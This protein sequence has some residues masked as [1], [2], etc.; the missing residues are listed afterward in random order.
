MIGDLESSDYER[1]FMV[2]LPLMPAVQMWNRENRRHVEHEMVRLVRHYEEIE[3]SFLEIVIDS[4]SK[5]LDDYNF[6]YTKHEEDIL[7]LQ[8]WLWSQRAFKYTQPVEDWFYTMY[9]PLEKEVKPVK[10][11]ILS[12]IREK[13]YGR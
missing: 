1:V 12:Y 2:H 8:K 3:N 5:F 11:N 4:E 7:T 10:F 13:Y 6:I 9:A